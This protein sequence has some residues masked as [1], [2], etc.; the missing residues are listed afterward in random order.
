[1]LLI[2]LKGRIETKE[3]YSATAARSMGIL[4]VIVARNS[5]VTVSGMDTLLKNV[6]HV[7]KIR[8]HKLFK[9]LL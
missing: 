2:L 6:L 8:E 9:L 4:P 7:Q 5:A 1:M 3:P